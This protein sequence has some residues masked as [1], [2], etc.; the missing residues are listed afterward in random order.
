MKNGLFFKT[1]RVCKIV[2]NCYLGCSIVVIVAEPRWGQGGQ[3]YKH[4]SHTHKL[5]TGPP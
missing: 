4:D 5:L 2:N 3:L 1:W